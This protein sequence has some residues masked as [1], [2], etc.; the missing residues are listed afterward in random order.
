M[1]AAGF[2]TTVNL[3]G[4]GFRICSKRQNTSRRWL[5]RPELWPTAVEEIL[6]LDSP[7]QLS[8]RIAAKDTEI[9]GPGTAG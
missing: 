6:R 3:L 4:N 2:E 8:A 5:G 7:V 1:L 9:A